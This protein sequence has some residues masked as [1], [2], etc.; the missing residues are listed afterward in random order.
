LNSNGKEGQR[1]LGKK[2]N[3][4]GF[5]FRGRNLS[6]A[7][8]YKCLI[9]RCI[10]HGAIC[11]QTNFANCTITKFLFTHVEFGNAT[12][13]QSRIID[14]SFS[15]SLFL[16]ASMMGS[17]S[18]QTDSHEQNNSFRH[19]DFKSS[20]IARIN[21][22]GSN[23]SELA[24]YDTKFE[25][26]NF[27]G[28]D[29][30]TTRIKSSIEMIEC[31]LSKSSFKAI[32]AEKSDFSYSNLTGVNFSE[33]NFMNSVVNMTSGEGMNFSKSDFN[34]SEMRLSSF[35]DADFTNCLLYQAD[36]SGSNLTAAMI[37]DTTNTN[38]TNLSACIWVDGSRCARRL[39][40]FCFPEA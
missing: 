22:S 9:D 3:L 2:E 6:Q 30:S 26:C 23:I 11:R 27:S 1:F 16:R 13:L 15:N 29:F 8:F 4:S 37:D 10:F 35:V 20:N 21:F 40:G 28:L 31:N 39:I 36:L 18:S 14:N 32:T 12:F 19:C 7:E 33:A 38:L 34:N 5:D 17:L 24:I 25:E